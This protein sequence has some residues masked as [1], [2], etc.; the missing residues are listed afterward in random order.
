MQN[1]RNL[2]DEID[3]LKAELAKAKQELGMVLGSARTLARTVGVGDMPM[4][5]SD[6]GRPH[7]QEVAWLHDRVHGEIVKRY[8][9]KFKE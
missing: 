2:T 3:R 8:T 9:Y 7:Y 5:C 1:A 6:G 4:R